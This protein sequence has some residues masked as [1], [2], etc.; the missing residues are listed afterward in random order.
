MMWA[1]RMP[2]VRA[3]RPKIIR[4]FVDEYYDLLPAHGRYN[5]DK[6]DPNI[7]LILQTGAKPL[8]TIC[9]KPKLLYPV[10]DHDIVEPN[11]WTE[12]EDLVY[13]VAKH[14]KDR[15]AG[16]RYWEVANEPDIGED[17]G[18]PYRFKPDSYVRYYQH[19]T[20]AVLRA[21]PDARVGGPALAS[22]RSPLLPALLEAAGRG[23]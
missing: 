6:L 5:F 22:V 1:S 16:I 10:V 23:D 8:M 19:T 9:F 13:N 17:G 7:D 21:D 4:I 12:W 20:A 18:T 3:L 14:Y 11:S 2:E 15:N